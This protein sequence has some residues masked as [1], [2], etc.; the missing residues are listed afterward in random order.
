M[1]GNKVKHYRQKYKI[2]QLEL[3]KKLNKSKQYISKLETNQVNVSVGLAISITNVF[4]E[5]TGEKTFGNQMI[6]LQVEDLFF[7]K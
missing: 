2:T 4:K 1:V 6:K 7:L 3:A 5:I